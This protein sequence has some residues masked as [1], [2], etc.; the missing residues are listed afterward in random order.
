MPYFGLVQPS[1]VVGLLCTRISACRSRP[2][3][4]SRKRNEADAASAKDFELRLQAQLSREANDCSLVREM[5]C[6]VLARSLQQTYLDKNPK[7]LLRSDRGVASRPQ[8]KRTI[9][10]LRTHRGKWL[11]VAV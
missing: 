5:Q 6:R 11:R 4:G 1:R 7:S 9:F 2:P 3:S 8:G 10:A